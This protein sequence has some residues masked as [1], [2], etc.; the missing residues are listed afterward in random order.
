MEG[1]GGGGQGGGE[2]PATPLSLIP[3]GCAL[4]VFV[5]LVV[6]L[7]VCFAV[8]QV[9]FK[10]AVVKKIQVTRETTQLLSHRR[11]P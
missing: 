1:G 2:T 4:P 9:Q 10:T 7:F 8:F 3:T 6:C 5:W 11:F